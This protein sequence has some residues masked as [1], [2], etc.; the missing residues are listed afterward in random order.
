LKCFSRHVFFQH[1]CVWM[2]A[3]WVISGLTCIAHHWCFLLI[4]ELG[5]P[6]VSGKWCTSSG[7]FR[8]RLYCCSF[9][10]EHL[11]F[12][13]LTLNTLYKYASTF[14]LP[15]F[16][17]EL[18]KHTIWFRA[19]ARRVQCIQR[20]LKDLMGVKCPTMTIYQ[21]VHDYQVSLPAQELQSCRGK[22]LDVMTVFCSINILRLMSYP[23]LVITYSLECYSPWREEI[24][25]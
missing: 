24:G 5:A 9:T 16:Y 11:W 7:A 15:Q 19:L 12:M 18:K 10:T 4:L 2:S 6:A 3:H 13:A 23:F 20:R 25:P 22:S 1:V 17:W 8:G 21:T 14:A